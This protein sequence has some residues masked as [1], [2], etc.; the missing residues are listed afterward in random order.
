MNNFEIIDFD[1]NNPEQLESISNVHGIVLPESN[2]TGLGQLFMKRFYYK[3][4]PKLGLL[5]C[6]LARYNNKTVGI[7]VCTK[8]PYSFIKQGMK[9]NVLK[10][11][12]ITGLSLLLKPSRLRALLHQLKYK[13]DPLLK[14]QEDAGLT[15]EILTLGVLKEFRTILMEENEKS[16]HIA[17]SM[18]DH[19]INYY[20][21]SGYK[22]MT[23]QILKTNTSALTFYRA[24]KA[25]YTDS[26]VQ[27]TGVLMKID[28]DKINNRK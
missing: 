1:Y 13:P 27:D 20:K 2:V 12:F 28:L 8:A 9:G 14:Q 23:G 17:F 7:I 26:T 16:T 5:K 21:K 6:F 10:L 25:T 22:F 11:L 15:I 4:L 24:Y 3:T 18:V 19:V